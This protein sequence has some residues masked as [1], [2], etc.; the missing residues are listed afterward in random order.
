[1][2]LLQKLYPFFLAV[3]TLSLG[4]IYLLHCL[5]EGHLWSN[6]HLLRS[7]VHQ[8]L[9]HLHESKWQTGEREPRLHLMTSL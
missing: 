3:L 2:V 1:M 7:P 4:F 9:C 5:E 8:V 6:K